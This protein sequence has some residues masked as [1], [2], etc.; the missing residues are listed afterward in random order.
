MSNVASLQIQRAERPAVTDVGISGLDSLNEQQ[1]FELGDH[2]SNIEHGLQWAIGDWYNAIPWGDKA[3]ACEKVG[4]NYK[5]A[6][7]C[8]D[9]ARA[10]QMPIRSGICSFKHHQVLT[11]SDLTANDRKRLLKK[12]EV[13]GLSSSKLKQ[14]RDIILGIAPLPPTVG[15][16]K[17]VSSLAGAVALEMPSASKAVQRKVVKGLE[18]LAKELKHEFTAAVDK[19]AESKAKVA[20]ENMKK[21]QARADE[22]YEKAL[23]L[24]AGV[25]AFITKDEFLLIRSCLHPDREAAPEKKS[26]AFDAFSKLAD[27]KN[28]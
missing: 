11:H 27:V 16:D 23:K 13:E 15:Y 10:F 19:A 18:K 6:Q 24:S 5:N 21:A 14:E 7:R 4:I 12:A 22:Q 20:R 25:K 17:G 26:R 28:W 9:V 2:L 3:A 1:F 8:G